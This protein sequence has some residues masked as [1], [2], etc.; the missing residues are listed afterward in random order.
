MQM[1]FHEQRNTESMKSFW[2]KQ[3]NFLLGW[4]EKKYLEEEKM[5]NLASNAVIPAWSMGI[6]SVSQLDDTIHYVSQTKTL[7]ML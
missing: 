3:I 7:M 4:W 1:K 6:A 2:A 5:I